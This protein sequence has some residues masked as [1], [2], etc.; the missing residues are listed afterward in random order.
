MINKDLLEQQVFASKNCIEYEKCKIFN[1]L[2][3]FFKDVRKLAFER[4]ASFI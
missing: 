4:I 3:F 1:F 2:S